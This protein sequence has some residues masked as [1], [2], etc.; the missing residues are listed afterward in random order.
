MVSRRRRSSTPELFAPRPRDSMRAYVE[1]ALEALPAL[2]LRPMFG[3][4]GIYSGDTMFAILHRGRVYLKTD[5]A[6]AHAFVQRGAGP[7]RPRPGS[8][9]KSYYEVPADVIDDP[10][11]LLDWARTALAVARGRAPTSSAR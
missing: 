7:F 11:R 10:E 3:G 4:A 5:P 1:D 8:T 2:E 6:G 9:L